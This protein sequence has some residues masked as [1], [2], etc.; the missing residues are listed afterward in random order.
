MGVNV[1]P[2]SGD[3]HD[4]WDR[5]C[6]KHEDCFGT[7][8]SEFGLRAARL[9]PGSRRENRSSGQNTDGYSREQLTKTGVFLIV[10]MRASAQ[11]RR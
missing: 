3:Q 5:T 10:P 11:M 6:A 8:P 4:H 9:L 1:E 2:V 7:E